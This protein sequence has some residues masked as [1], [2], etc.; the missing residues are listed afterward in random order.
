M[1]SFLFVC[2]KKV[3][4][5]HLNGRLLFR[6]EAFCFRWFHKERYDCGNAIVKSKLGE[7]LVGEYPDGNER[8]K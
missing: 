1:E 6:I 7:K 5:L 8:C 4:H 3:K 2:G